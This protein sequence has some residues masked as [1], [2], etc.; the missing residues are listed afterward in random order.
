MTRWR[1]LVEGSCDGAW[2]MAVDRAIQEARQADLA[3]PTLR[4]YRWNVPTVS[5]G[6]FQTPESVDLEYCAEQGIDVVRRYTG[7]RGVLHDDELTYSFVAGT[8]DG[9]PRSVVASYRRISSALMEAY[10]AMGVDARI[11]AGARGDATSAACY[12]H[13]TKA[14]LSAGSAKIA[15]SA[16]VWQEDTCLQHGSFTCGRDIGR[17]ARVF[18]LDA[19]GSSVLGLRTVTLSDLLIEVPAVEELAEIVEAAFSRVFEVRFE[20]GALCEWEFDRARELVESRRV[21]SADD[22]MSAG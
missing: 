20:P 21:A 14:D 10:R 13:A 4:L 15:G 11:V 3:L 19:Q 5:I 16:Q 9:L 18:R 6:R 17:E 8:Q 22:S 12:L 7:G 2:N 1:L